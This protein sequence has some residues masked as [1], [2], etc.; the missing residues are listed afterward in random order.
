MTKHI[1]FGAYLS[2]AVFLLSAVSIQA[3]ESEVIL[4][5][6]QDNTLYLR[7]DEALSNGGGPNFFVGKTKSLGLR[8]GLLQFD[9]TSIPLDA[10]IRSVELILNMD[11]SR[12]GEYVVGL[13]KVTNSWG[14][15]SSTAVKGGGVGGRC[16]SR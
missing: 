13:H 4:S 1:T 14:E 2:V 7:G 8:R 16:S 5:P 12:A 9:V 10:E 6:T 15:S 3:E 11:R